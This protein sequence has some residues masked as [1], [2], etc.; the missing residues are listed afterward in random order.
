[1]YIMIAARTTERLTALQLW[2]R[3][4][5]IHSC[6]EKEQLVSKLTRSWNLGSTKPFGSSSAA[7]SSSDKDLI[8]DFLANSGMV[9][10][11]VFWNKVKIIVRIIA[12]LCILQFVCIVY[13]TVL[14]FCT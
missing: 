7:S 2:K 6:L 3:G 8:L 9:L 11:Y 13:Y 5:F 4:L 14:I 12:E 10:Q 1:M